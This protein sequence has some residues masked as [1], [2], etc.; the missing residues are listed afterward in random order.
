MTVSGIALVPKIGGRTGRDFTVTADLDSDV[1]TTLTLELATGVIPESDTREASAAFSQALITTGRTAGYTPL[2]GTALAADATSLPSDRDG[3]TATKPIARRQEFIIPIRW[4]EA[5]AQAQAVNSFTSADVSLAIGFPGAATATITKGSLCRVGQTD[6]WHQRVT[7]TRTSAAGALGSITC[8]IRASALPASADRTPSQAATGT[9]HYQMQGP[10]PVVTVGG[11]TRSGNTYS[12]NVSWNA[13][14]TGQFCVGD[15]QLRSSNANLVISNPSLATRQGGT[16][17]GEYR[18]SC[19]LSSAE[20]TVLSI[21]VLENAIP[22][23]DARAGSARTVLRVAAIGSLGAGPTPT[24]GDWRRTADGST[25]TDTITQAL[26]FYSWIDFPWV[27]SGFDSSDVQITVPGI[28]GVTGTASIANRTGGTAGQNYLLTVQLTSTRT[29]TC[30]GD[31][32]VTLPAGAVPPAGLQDGSFAATKTFTLQV[33]GPAPVI[34]IGDAQLT[35][36]QIHFPVMFDSDFTPSDFTSADCSITASSA[37]ITV[38][39]VVVARTTSG[40]NTRGWSVSAP[41]SGE[42]DST[43]TLLI[44]ENAIPVTNERFGSAATSRTSD[45]YNIAGGRQ[46]G[47]PGVESWD[48]PDEPVTAGDVEVLVSFD[49]DVTKLDGT[50]LDSSVFRLEGL[51]GIEDKD[52]VVTPITDTTSD[53]DALKLRVYEMPTARVENGTAFTF[54]VVGTGCPLPHALRTDAIDVSAGMV[55]NLCNTRAGREWAVTVTTP[56]T[57]SGVITITAVR[58]IITTVQTPSNLDDLADDNL[59]YEGRTAGQFFVIREAAPGRWIRYDI[60]NNVAVPTNLDVGIPVDAGARGGVVYSGHLYVG[61]DGVLNGV[62][63]DYTLAGVG[64]DSIRDILNIF[65]PSTITATTDKIYGLNSVTSPSV[66]RAVTGTRPTGFTR[67]PSNDITL[68]GNAGGTALRR[69]N[70]VSDGTRIWVTGLSQNRQVAYAYAYTIATRQRD[71]ANDVIIRDASDPIKGI[72]SDG[73]SLYFIHDSNTIQPYDI[74]LGSRMDGF[75]NLSA[76]LVLGTVSY[77]TA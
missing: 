51:S 63:G 15:F 11:G 22:E 25:S 48:V 64:I 38:G 1:R 37:S 4:Q 60:A 69:M 73:V 55:T 70:L 76:N 66:I 43:L 49:R 8:S 72:T 44:R 47:A 21:V 35:G 41:V 12:F 67:C 5:A 24:I 36:G 65:V 14:V 54:R 19:T 6:T 10:A 62:I 57:G 23:T 58:Q 33:Q 40:S 53:A 3:T 52:I 39:T 30:T 42:A 17:G 32:V 77:G 7:V 26:T 2:I 46:A 59:P 29:S 16:P 28:S 13:D 20:A 56:S 71:I 45:S 50:A 68:V 74:F 9:F 61:A 34:T 31:V 18:I 27:V 75:T